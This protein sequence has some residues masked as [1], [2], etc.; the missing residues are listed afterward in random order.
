MYRTRVLGALATACLMT[1]AGSAKFQLAISRSH[2]LVQI[3][4]NP[5]RKPAP[6]QRSG[7]HNNRRPN[8][9]MGDWLRSHQSLPP[10]QQEKLLESDP[11]FKKLPPDRQARFKERLRRF[12]SLPPEQR[13]RV[14]ARMQFMASLTQ[15]QRKEIRDANQKLEALPPERRVMVH[16]ALRHLREMDPQQRQQALQSERFRSTFSQPEQEIVKQLVSISPQ[17]PSAAQQPK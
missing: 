10:D 8:G 13:E 15:E 3:Q 12:N 7:N 16:A 2:S 9:K 17:R 5:Q 11:N 6:A 14:L 1:V 4:Q